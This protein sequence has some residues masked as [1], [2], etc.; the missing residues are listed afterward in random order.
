VIKPKAMLSKS[1]NLFTFFLFITT[2]IV[3]VSRNKVKSLLNITESLQALLLQ[4]LV[5]P[6]LNC[7]PQS[8]LVG[9]LLNANVRTDQY[10]SANL[11]VI[12]AALL[13]CVWLAR[14]LGLPI[15]K[16]LCTEVDLTLA[17]VPYIDQRN[18]NRLWGFFPFC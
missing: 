15:E 12:A 5:D 7:C 1:L 13:V 3:I 10:A 17:L 14:F 4:H 2:S 8:V 16:R 18:R 11:I 6:A 9:C